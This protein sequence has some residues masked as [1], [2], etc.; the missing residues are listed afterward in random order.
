VAR[1]IDSDRKH[2]TSVLRAAADHPGAAFIEI[3]QNCP[4][5]NDD[6]FA[7]LKDA[8]SRDDQLI[9][10]Q[11]GEPIRFGAAGQRGLR[12]ARYGGLEAV[13]VAAVDSESLLV[14][15]A[16]QDDPSYAFALSRLDT[17]AAA[18]TPI[19]VFRKVER[20]SYDALMAQQVRETQT[21]QG[22]GDL[23]TLLAGGDS[24]TIR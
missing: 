6:A 3:Y 10:L 23:A 22:A 19:G 4:I 13:D 12:A 1:S 17:A 11:D 7:P 24:W 15:D 5:F 18:H 8:S 14:H 16:G 21:K 2:L 9:R 20:P